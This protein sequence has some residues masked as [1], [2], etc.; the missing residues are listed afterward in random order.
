MTF[1]VIEGL[2]GCGGETQTKL[3]EKYFKSEEILF[4]TFQSPDYSTPIG[5]AIRSYLNEKMKLDPKSAFTLFASDTLLKSK[6]VEVSRKKK[7]V[8]M[9]RYI[10]S[11]LPYQVARGLNFIKGAEII[12]NLDYQ[13]PD[14][15]IYLD[16][17]P[18][19][20]MERKKEE[21]KELDYHEKDLKY[22][23]KVREIYL[24]E[25]DN[26]ILGTWFLIDAERS[27]PA[28]HKDILK[29]VKSLL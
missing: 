1:I 20:S 26:N 18:E 14:A 23:E 13:K 8:L 9:D 7:L 16:I 28:V 15:I 25:A 17:K 19:T 10:T 29:V 2:D 5:K 12:E 22:L 24:R 21:K 4:E 11:T 6:K 3:L 27:I